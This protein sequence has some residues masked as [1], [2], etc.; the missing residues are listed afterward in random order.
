MSQDKR[1]D[2]SIK[3]S[4]TQM[5]YAS[6][7]GE[8]LALDEIN[9]D[10]KSGEFSCIV[11]P[12]GCG[13]STLL[14]LIAGLRDATKGKIE[15]GQQIVHGPQTDVGIVFQKDVLLD[16]R[17]S[18]ENVL[19]QIEM[20]KLNKKNYVDRA[21]YLLDSIGLAG[22]EHKRPAELSG[23]MRQR[24]SIC[25]AL[26]HDPQ[27]LLM[28]EPFGALDALTREQLMVELQHIWMDTKKTVVFITH[29]I[30]EAVF[31]A[32]RV[33]IISPRPGK[34]SEIV[35]IDLP[36]PRSLLD[37]DPKVTAYSKHIRRALGVLP[38]ASGSSAPQ[39]HSR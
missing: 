2:G 24:V 6:K 36:R 35:D 4:K 3:I 18:L 34:I 32:D 17:S 11:G 26:L 7:S 39:G 14:M 20:R 33:F 25:R 16:W 12:S 22:F 5:L 19:F 9:L 15:I 10:I 21:M 37:P 23:G 8:T 29:S 31:L 27:V 28:D 30:Q 1:L 38:G 13:K